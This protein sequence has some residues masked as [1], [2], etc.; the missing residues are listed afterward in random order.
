MMLENARRLQE[1]R[2]ELNSS[3]NESVNLRPT[4]ITMLQVEQYLLQQQNEYQKRIL[5]ANTQLQDVLQKQRDYTAAYIEQLEHHIQQVQN[6]ISHRRLNDSQSTVRE[7]L[8]T[9]KPILKRNR[10]PLFKRNCD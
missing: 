2:N 8:S 1:I 4:Q 3:L 5:Q 6:A 9:S 7:A 10:I